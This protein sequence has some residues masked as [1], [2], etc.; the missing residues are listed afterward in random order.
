MGVYSAHPGRKAR[1]ESQD[2]ESTKHRPPGRHARMASEQHGPTVVRQLE[3]PEFLAL[4]Y[5][6]QTPVAVLAA[7]VV[8]GMILGAFYGLRPVG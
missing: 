4:N 5:G 2:L 6:A 1:R 8:F 3:P 7:H